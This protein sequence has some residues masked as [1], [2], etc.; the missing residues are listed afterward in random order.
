MQENERKVLRAAARAQQRTGVAISIH[1]GRNE[2]A[3]EE[4]LEVLREAGADL[5]CVVMGHLDR[6]AFRWDVMK[7]IAKSGC[8]LEFDLFGIENS[9]FPL[10]PHIDM[11]NDSTRLQ[12]IE[13]RRLPLHCGVHCPPH[14]R[15]G[16]QRGA[17][18]GHPGGQP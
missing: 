4:I 13:R 9:H 10:N 2:A 6:T 5:T 12:W 3:P 14:A 15:Q 7:R 11:P 18:T 17:H 8:Y 16:L 1:P